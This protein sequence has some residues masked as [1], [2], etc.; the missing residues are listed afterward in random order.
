MAS[1][2]S[3]G[4]AGTF[5]SS[6]SRPRGDSS[7]VPVGRP[8]SKRNAQGELISPKAVLD[9]L[10]EKRTLDSIAMEFNYGRTYYMKRTIRS[11]MDGD[12]RL[13]EEFRRILPPHEL[14]AIAEHYSRHQ[15]YMEARKQHRIEKVVN[16]TPLDWFMVEYRKTWDLSDAC[17][18]AFPEAQDPQKEFIDRIDPEKD[19]YDKEWFEAWRTLGYE[20]R[21]KLDGGAWTKALNDRD[22]AMIR[23]L[24]EKTIP[25]VYGSKPI[26]LEVTHLFSNQG[27]MKAARFMHRS[28]G[29]RLEGSRDDGGLSALTIDS[30]RLPS[31]GEETPDDEGVGEDAPRA[32][33]LSG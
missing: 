8:I 19:T 28:F 16:R 32:V 30:L 1:P 9:R 10:R 33:A 14:V 3:P 26:Q 11:W 18:A 12:V 24:L 2:E 22:P 7:R 31:A 20:K 25:E 4:E 21:L 15:R 17:K 6:V 29:E 5:R 27:Y 13:E 23:W